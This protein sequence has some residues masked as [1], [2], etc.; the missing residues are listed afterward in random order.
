M[1][2]EI[3]GVKTGIPSDYL[4]DVK[5]KTRKVRK[6][7]PPPEKSALKQE[8]IDRSMEILRQ[9]YSLFNRKLKFSIN[10]EIDRVI[11]KVIDANTDKLIKEIPPQEIQ[12]LIARIKEAIGIL[13]DE[14]I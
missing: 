3:L 4:S 13:F 11:V 10:K 1:G 2:M 9:T 7:S 5:T 8:S 14:K 6:K 12:R